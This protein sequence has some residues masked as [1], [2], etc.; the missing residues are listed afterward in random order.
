MKIRTKMFF[1]AIFMLFLGA[2]VY[3]VGY[4]FFIEPCH[5]VLGGATGVATLLNYTLSLPVGVGFLLL[6]IP[7]LVLGWALRGFLSILRSAIGIVWS[8]AVL[9]ALSLVKMAEVPLWAGAIL[10]GIFTALGIAMLLWKDFTTG[11]TELAAILIHERFSRL[12]VGKIM[13]VID[14]A[15]VLFSVFIMKR[16]ETLVYSVVLNFSFAVTLDAFLTLIPLKNQ[17]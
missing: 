1:N 9:E 15:I 5:I 6:N 10:G 12:A 2:I 7:L 17:V 4:R 14:T 16:A 13:L 8:A 11:G 3:A